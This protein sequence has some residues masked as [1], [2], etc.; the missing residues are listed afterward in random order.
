ML[1]A[2]LRRNR[3][4]QWWWAGAAVSNTGSYMPTTAV[5]LL[6]LHTDGS[7]SRAGLV[8]GTTALACTR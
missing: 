7:A 4:H 8:A 6:V 1:L 3:D 2:P 5:P